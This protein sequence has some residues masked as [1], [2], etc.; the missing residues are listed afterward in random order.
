MGHAPN[1]QVMHSRRLAVW[2]SLFVAGGWGCREKAKL[3]AFD[4]ERRGFAV[5]CGASKDSCSL[6]QQTG[7][8]APNY[9]PEL[10]AVGRLVGVCDSASSHLGDCRPFDCERDT[11]CPPAPGGTNGTCIGSLCVEPS[12]PIRAEDAVMLCMAG[13]GLGHQRR[14]QV[15][16]YAL[17]IN[18][19]DPCSIP[20]PCRQP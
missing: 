13:T 2:L 20:A 8:S 18:C 12:H 14:D 5:D 15:E 4:T 7:P 11:D 1:F 17:G 6:V 19:G 16:R 10:R 3:V 9:T